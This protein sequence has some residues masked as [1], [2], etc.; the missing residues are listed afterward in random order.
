MEG[1]KGARDMAADDE[2]TSALVAA[3]CEI[4]I[5]QVAK[6]CSEYLEQKR[7]LIEAGEFTTERWAKLATMLASV[8]YATL[9][10]ALSTARLAAEQADTEDCEG[11]YV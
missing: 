9:D 6:L 4:G 7:R 3:C 1:E 2:I 10:A 8:A 5:E 11:V